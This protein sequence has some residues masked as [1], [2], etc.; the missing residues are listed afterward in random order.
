MTIGRKL[1]S[2]VSVLALLT[3]ALGVGSWL[4]VSR[5]SDKLHVVTDSTWVK[6]ALAAKINASTSDLLAG[7]RGI[8]V[9]GYM[10]D[11]GSMTK[12][13]GQ[14]AEDAGDIEHALD[15]MKPLLIL[16]RG[17]ALTADL[18]INLAA[19]TAANARVYERAMAGDPEAAAK[20]YNDEFL[21]PQK[22]MKA[23]AV[24]LAALETELTVAASTEARGAATLSAEIT[25][26]L[27]ALSLV[28]LVGLVY[29]V[30]GV[31]RALRGTVQELSGAAGQIGA[32]S[33]QV[34][35]SSQT[36][37]QGAS[38]QAARIEETSSASTEINSMAQRTTET[39]GTMVTMMTRSEEEFGRTNVALGEMVTAMEEIADSSRKISKIIKV[40]DDI[41]FQTNILALNAAVEAAR[42]GAA[43]SGFAVVA[44]EVRN[45]AQR[46]AQAA[47]DTAVLIEDSMAR[48]ES[49][50]EKVQRV[51]A[52][53]QTVTKESAAV[54]ALM[55]EVQ[56]G[57]REQTA[58][59]S[60]ISRSMSQME[61]GTQANAA[62]AEESAAAAEELSGQARAMQEVAE[63]LTAMVDGASGPQGAGVQRAPAPA[64]G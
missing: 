45:L 43:G 48:S 54:K 39:S 34:S 61:Q 16:P 15:T 2:G 49:G 36:M 53:I 17:H 37:A 14:F 57:S 56:E 20:I 58:G 41:A 35:A 9:R 38:E 30:R 8:L 46:C 4:G 3:L 18:A 31:N 51:A 63:R 5:V 32:A 24:Q 40:I 1:F 6:Y 50:R 42:A 64:W 29:V 27:L 13:N 19:V 12:Y 44:D 23:G 7:D 62:S 59:F 47:R 10:K 11:P 55:L 60:Q 25:A 33:G 21:P 28:F 26:G 22:R 52:G